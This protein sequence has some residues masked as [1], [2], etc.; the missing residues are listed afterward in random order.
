MEVQ[1]EMVK[2]SLAMATFLFGMLLLLIWGGF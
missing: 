1:M 2:D